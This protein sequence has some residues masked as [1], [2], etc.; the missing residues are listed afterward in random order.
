MSKLKEL[1]LRPGTTADSQ[2]QNKYFNK[3]HNG[4]PTMSADSAISRNVMQK[5]NKNTEEEELDDYV[6]SVN[7]MA[8]LKEYSLGLDNLLGLGKS[9]ANVC[10]S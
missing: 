5:V 1:N 6:D 2:P 4:G 10:S 3:S 9:A 7:D 8:I